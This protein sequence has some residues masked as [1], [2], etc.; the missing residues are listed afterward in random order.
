M[1]SHAAR[2]SL[3]LLNLPLGLCLCAVVTWY[4]FDVRPA[5]A[6]A[7]M[8]D[9]ATRQPPASWQQIDKS[10][11]REVAAAER[12]ALQ[13]PVSEGDLLAH[14]LDPQHAL[15][16]PR[17]FP[18]SGP[19]PSN[20]FREP[21][22]EPVSQAPRLETLG[23]VTMAMPGEDD[24]LLVFAFAGESQGRLYQTGDRL[25]QGLDAE[26][27]YRIGAA[28]CAE[29]G[30][31][32]IAYGAYAVGKDVALFPGVLVC[33]FRSGVRSD[34][35]RLA[36]RTDGSGTPGAGINPPRPGNGGL[37]AAPELVGVHAL[38]P[39][40][41]A[42]PTDPTRTL[43]EFDD[44]SAGLLRSEEG[45]RILGTMKTRSRTLPGGRQGLEILDGG[46]VPLDRFSLKRGDVIVSIESQPT[47]DKEA[48]LRVARTIP[49]ESTRVTVGVERNGRE[50][51]FVV[52]PRDAKTRRRM[53]RAAERMDEAD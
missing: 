6:A 47:P 34:V 4:A 33:D 40:V 3:W 8:P 28:R 43:V 26:H 39:K 51:T 19:R 46:E 14:L 29:V 42:D 41:K 49:P 44:A 45:V 37:P 5:V 9:P 32:E 27:E 17:Y 22:P 30:R 1:K 2:H 11:Q 12:H 36:P 24:A 25:R 10:F 48:V 35:I 18:F 20:R 23:R 38:R 15:M 7:P 16:T 53:A 13:S 50:L 52:D 21:V 31:I